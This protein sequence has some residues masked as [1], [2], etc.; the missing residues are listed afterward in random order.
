[1]ETAG[2]EI[3]EAQSKLL[4]KR[5]LNQDKNIHLIEN[6]EPVEDIILRCKE[7]AKK[8]QREYG[9][10]NPDEFSPDYILKNSGIPRLYQQCSFNNFHG[11]EEGLIEDIKSI[12]SESIVL[13]GKTGCGKTHLAVSILLKNLGIDSKFI[14]VPGLLLKIRSSFNGGPE[15]EEEVISKFSGYKTLVLDDLGAEKTSEFS[16]TTLYLILDQR[17]SEERQTIITTNLSQKEI[18]DVFGVRIASRLSGME[19][20]KINMPDYRKKR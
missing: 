13:R 4:Q 18:E 11:A 5:A 20:I 7:K 15:T 17:I 16:I 9:V 19:N 10:M 2:Q 12:T 14:S 3:Q 1:M 8:F 6:T